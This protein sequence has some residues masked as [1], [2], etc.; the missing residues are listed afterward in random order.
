MNDTLTVTPVGSGVRFEVRVQP[1]AS[2]NEV[3]GIY[4]TALKI[5]LSAPPVEGAA[6]DALVEYLAELL[7][8]PRRKV[9][10][11]S[12]LSSRQKTVQA[13]GVDA[14]RVHA[15]AEHASRTRK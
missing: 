13:D 2:R 9:T 12:G 5:R 15:L 4:G 3:A 11:I 8:V 6:N 10:I 7:G 14:G 1:R